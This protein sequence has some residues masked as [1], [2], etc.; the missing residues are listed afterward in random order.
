MKWKFMELNKKF[1]IISIT[2]VI[3]IIIF[4]ALGTLYP[5]GGTC[6]KDDKEQRFPDDFIWGAASSAY[7]IE[8]AWNV[9]GKGESIWDHVC[10]TD[11]TKI[12]DQTNGDTTAN[13]YELYKEDVR[14]LKNTG[15]KFYRFS[16]SWPRIL[17]NGSHTKINDL[18]LQYYDNLINELLANGIQPIVTMFHWDLPQALQDFGG[19]LNPVIVDYFVQY[20]KLLIEHFGDRVKIWNTFNEPN[21]FCEYGYGRK[22][23]AP[24]VNSDGVGP[25]LC[26]YHVLLANAKVYRMYH[27]HYN[28][29]KIGKI[30]LVIQSH[31]YYPKDSKKPEDVEAANRMIEFWLGQYSHPIFSK[32][33][34]YP[35]LM[36][37]V[38]RKNSLAEGLSGSRLPSLLMR[39]RLEIFQSHPFCT[40]AN[41][42]TT[43]DENWPVAA[44]SWLRSIPDG[45]RKLLNWIKK[46]YD[47]PPLMITENGWS[48]HGEI[49]DIGRER[50]LKGHLKAIQD[51]I[52]E[53]GCNVIGHMTWSIIDNFEWTFGYT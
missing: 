31:F 46:E 6:S 42:F 38:I 11:P 33:G 36:V 48:D 40:D 21:I 19:M 17:P 26:N 29:D 23:H 12:I 10:H 44:S 41:V 9:D 20:A 35:K 2:A 4:I 32:T 45:L 25:Y 22:L 3:V 5:I 8:G 7:Q 43:Q 14:A 28:I 52:L 24:F 47:N 39:P 13:S 37:D 16:V 50:Y 27:E 18:G 49:E 15:F 30:G 1:W 51:A 34:G 53:D